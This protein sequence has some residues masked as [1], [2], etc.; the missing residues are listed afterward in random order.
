[1]EDTLSSYAPHRLDTHPAMAVM[2]TISR[3]E[4]IDQLLLLAGCFDRISRHSTSI[5]H[6]GTRKVWDTRL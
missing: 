1:M 5:E 4:H 3:R 2:A 6:F